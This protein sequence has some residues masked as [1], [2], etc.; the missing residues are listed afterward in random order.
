MSRRARTISVASGIFFALMAYL[1]WLRRESILR[2][3]TTSVLRS[4]PYSSIASGALNSSLKGV[5]SE[6]RSTV[7]ENS[8]S[9]GA[10]SLNLSDD[11]QSTK[12]APYGWI[13][14]SNWAGKGGPVRE[15]DYEL[16]TDHAN[17]SHGKS[18]ALLRSTR[19]VDS[20]SY[21]AI[22]QRVNVGKLAG[23]RVMFSAYLATQ[24]AR[25]GASLWF[26]VN[27][28]QG[29]VVA[30]E[31][32]GLSKVVATTP[33][34]QYSIVIDVPDTAATLL[35]GTILYGDGTVWMDMADLVSIDRSI[36]AAPPQVSWQNTKVN[37]PV[38]PSLTLAAPQ[39]LDF[40]DT[41]PID[42]PVFASDA[43]KDTRAKMIAA[44]T[45]TQAGECLETLMVKPL[46]DACEL[47]LEG[48][49]AMLKPLGDIRRATYGGT[50]TLKGGSVPNVYWVVFENGS[51]QFDA[52][53]NDEG[54]LAVL[55]TDTQIFP[56]E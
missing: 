44:L 9:P 19:S 39:N 54:K 12:M 50:V 43:R 20:S 21:G 25:A 36:V 27:D 5:E 32:M 23:Q 15:T 53:L 1:L 55:L 48:N 42:Q 6:R 7:V 45:A 41:V 34:K 26:R 28:Q 35:Y 2:E 40:E 18:S 11:S 14:A 10:V 24:D 29:N 49:Q 22:L 37:P 4:E 16:V 17:V 38:D 3:S 56:K 31:D 47:Q 46:L 51:M 52:S 8:A 30:F 13:K 33:W